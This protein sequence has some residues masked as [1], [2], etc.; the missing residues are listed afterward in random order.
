MTDLTDLVGADL[1]VVSERYP[2]NAVGGAE[3]SLHLTLAKLAS[4]WKIVVITFDDA[5]ATQRRSVDGINVLAFPMLALRRRD[6]RGCVLYL[7]R[8]CGVPASVR[9]LQRIP[10]RVKGVDSIGAGIVDCLS[11][12]TIRDHRWLPKSG[13]ETLV[14]R[15][16]EHLRPA[17][18]HADN[19][20]AIIYS[21]GYCATAGAL[22][23]CMVRDNRFHCARENQS[24]V[25]KGKACTDCDLSCAALDAPEWAGLQQR[26]LHD[27]REHRSQALSSFDR[28]IVTS[29]YL[30]SSLGGDESVRV[31][32]VVPNS[33]GDV[34]TIEALVEGVAERPGYNLLVVGMLNS[35]KGQ[36]A[37]LSAAVEWM[38]DRGDV[39]VHFAGRGDR[40][41]THLKLLACQ[42]GVH[43]R[44]HFHGYLGRTKMFELYREC[45]VAVAPVLWEEPFGR[46]PLEAGVV[47][48][49]CVAF[50]SGG[51]R[52]SIVDGQTGFVVPK[53]DYEGLLARLEELRCNP[54]LRR[55]MGDRGNEHV[56]R[57]YSSDVHIERFV[58]ALS[59][60]VQVE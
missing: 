1:L 10:R 43:E 3:L 31:F 26:V 8:E 9:D 19:Y 51:L 12:R 27:V 37:F 24:A 47:R 58:R 16:A 39:N 59:M 17:R 20:R 35:N 13:L 34:D 57:S 30:R 6:L 7:L 56:R 46:V 14:S 23:T 38:Q 40:E 55:Q 32:G 33:V 54:S 22:T 45:D 53:G 49:P 44:V 18:I 2:P 36:S 11:G 29:E 52:E 60:D 50:G 42:H 48:K 4:T 21:A 41:V 28:V 15:V 25:V 5:H